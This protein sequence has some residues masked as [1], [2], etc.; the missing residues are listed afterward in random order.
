LLI[1]PLLPVACPL[2]AG[3][4]DRMGIRKT[5]FPLAAFLTECGRPRADE[6]MDAQ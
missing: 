3:G 2:T 6:E 1:F 4:A 5:F